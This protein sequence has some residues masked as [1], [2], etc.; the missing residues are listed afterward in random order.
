VTLELVLPPGRS[1]AEAY[2]LAAPSVESLDQVT[3][4][5]TQVSAQGTWSPGPAE[6]IEL[7]EAVASLHVPAANAVLVRLF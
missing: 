6:K 1:R 3:L 4:A 2:R 7:S 5:G